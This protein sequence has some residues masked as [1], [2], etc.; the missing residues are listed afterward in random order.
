MP[1]QSIRYDGKL[2]RLADA[3][4]YAGDVKYSFP[5]WSFVVD[6]H[7]VKSVVDDLQATGAGA[8]VRLDQEDLL[9]FLGRLVRSTYQE[10]IK[11]KSELL[12]LLAS[13]VL[14]REAFTNTIQK[15]RNVEGALD[16]LLV[17][18]AVPESGK[19]LDFSNIDAFLDGLEQIPEQLLVARS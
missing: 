6:R 12:T 15:L 18:Q 3:T 8:P 7:E 16:K 4:P 10:D 1:A 9:A 19:Y 13:E 17:P 2:Y 11:A 5:H 14:V